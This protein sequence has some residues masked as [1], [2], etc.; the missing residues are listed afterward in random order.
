MKAPIWL[1]IL[2]SALIVGNGY[3][4]IGTMQDAAN[5]A[6]PALPFAPS[7]RIILAVIWMMLLVAVLLGLLRGHPTAFT[8]VAPLLTVYGAIGL[9]WNALYAQSSYGRGSQP[10]DVLLTLIVLAPVWWTAL[11]RGWLK[12]KI[13]LPGTD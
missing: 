6:A 9:V 7:I 1:L 3:V 10:F 5:N 12:L 8:L 4:I 13:P 2:L 11:R